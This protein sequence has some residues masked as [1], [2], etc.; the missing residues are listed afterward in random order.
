MHIV[1]YKE[2]KT[3]N[4]TVPASPLLGKA[5]FVHNVTG[6]QSK[7]LDQ[8]WWCSKPILLR[9][10]WPVVSAAHQQLTK[11][12]SSGRLISSFAIKVRLLSQALIWS[13]M[14]IC[15]VC[16][17]CS[18][19][20]YL[21]CLFCSRSDQFHSQLSLC[22]ESAGAE[23]AKPAKKAQF[24]LCL[25]TAR[26]AHL[27]PACGTLSQQQPQ[28]WWRG[29]MQMNRRLQLLFCRN[30]TSSRRFHPC[31][32]TELEWFTGEL[33]PCV[34][35]PGNCIFIPDEFKQRFAFHSTWTALHRICLNLFWKMR[36]GNLQSELLAATVQRC[37]CSKSCVHEE[38]VRIL[39]LMKQQQHYGPRHLKHLL[40][41]DVSHQMQMAV[42]ILSIMVT[43]VILYGIDHRLV[44]FC[45]QDG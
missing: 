13:E 33:H 1:R 21:F 23:S 5:I 39:S 26:K 37:A 44:L 6:Q 30:L 27:S 42:Q 38:E 8:N 17:W 34:L 19:C 45:P 35:I 15:F 43:T 4:V 12:P 20:I 32:Y 31:N 11:P 28:P 36:C 7:V 25:S 3:L 9:C 41:W 14:E 29:R 22:T 24:Y 10:W 2:K 16:S 18:R 40:P